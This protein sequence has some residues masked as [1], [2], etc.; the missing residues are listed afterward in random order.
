MKKLHPQIEQEVRHRLAKAREQFN[1]LTQ[2]IY[3]PS[4]NLDQEYGP[5]THQESTELGNRAA[6][7]DQ[8][9]PSHGPRNGRP[10]DAD[11]SE[12]MAGRIKMG[13]HK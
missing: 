10:P 1:R 11:S 7:S 2:D 5:K 12:S 13:R 9:G 4:A 8:S 3:P 6:Q